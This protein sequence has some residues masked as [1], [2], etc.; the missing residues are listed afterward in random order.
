MRALLCLLMA[1]AAFAERPLSAGEAKGVDPARAR[2]AVE[3]ALVPIQTSMATFRQERKCFSCHHHAVPIVVLSEAREFGFEIDEDRFASQVSHTAE[4]VRKTKR[5]FL[6]GRGPGGRVDSA[7][8]SL[9]A[10][11]AGGYVDAEVTAPAIQYLLQADKA[12]GYWGGSTRR[13]PTMECDA[14]RTALSLLA[15]D[16]YGDAEHQDKIAARTENARR[17]LRELDPRLTEEKVFRLRALGHL[18]ESEDTLAEFARELI[19]DQRPDGGWAQTSE[20]DS[21]A[22]ATA[23]VLSVL[24][25]YDLLDVNDAAYHRAAHW[26]LDKQLSDGTWHVTT[27]STPVQVYFESGFPHGE[28]Q[29]ISI[30]ATCWAVAA[31]LPA[32]ENASA[33]E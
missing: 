16:Y 24:C 11:H 29:F 28:D 13:G 23:T 31:L 7:G 1:G 10:L 21:D 30:Y 33:S 6:Q 15:L 4:Q 8:W 12:S 22:Y 9:W 32:C 19:E 17:W 26:L 25:K 20:S 3:T 18:Q 27:R 5:R 14:T 2:S